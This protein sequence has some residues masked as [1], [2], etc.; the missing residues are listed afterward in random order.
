MPSLFL[1]PKHELY[2]ELVGSTFSEQISYLSFPEFSIG[3]AGSNRYVHEFPSVRNIK[4]SATNSDS[5]QQSTVTHL[6]A[7]LP[8][9][10]MN[11]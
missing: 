1:L 7:C 6:M 11:P 3:V 5:W 8:H 10:F 2:Y 4:S 9:T